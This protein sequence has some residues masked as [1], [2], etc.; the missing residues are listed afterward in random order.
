[1]PR[2][3]AV[4]RIGEA[5]AALGSITAAFPTHPAVSRP[6]V[7]DAAVAPWRPFAPVGG[8]F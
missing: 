5:N 4:Q 1:V 6:D 3:A 2:V 8:S 7:S